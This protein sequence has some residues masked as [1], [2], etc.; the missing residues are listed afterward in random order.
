[1]R[2]FFKISGWLAVFL[3]T[4]IF[5]I[6][7]ALQSPGVQTFLA[8]K[9]LHFIEGTVNADISFEKVHVRP[10]NALVLKDV[11]IVDRDPFIPQGE[12]M[13]AQQD[14]FF[15][16]GY[17]TATFSLK[18]LF[19]GE[20]LH[21][22][23]VT[24]KDGL[25]VLAT[26]PTGSNLKRIIQTKKKEKKEKKG[27]AIF[28]ANRVEVD[29]MEFRLVNF[30][31]PKP[32]REGAI[33]W[34]DLDVF[35]INL[36]GRK[37]RFADGVM[38]GIADHLSFTEK[39]GYVVRDMSGKASVGN[40]RTK[41][42][43][44]HIL[45]G[46]SNLK[47]SSFSMSYPDMTA[48]KDFV[49]RVY[50]EADIEPSV[51][52]IE[53]VAYFA[54]GLHKN[55]MRV[56]MRTKFEGYVS[57]FTVKGLKFTE[58][59][60][61]MTA[62][63]DGGIIGLPDSQGM[64][65]DFDVKNMEFT[66]S[67]LSTFIKGW[68]PKANLNLGNI[69]PGETFTMSAKAKGPLNRLSAQADI[70]SPSGG[71]IADVDLRNLIDKKRDI[72]I[73][74]QI[75]TRDLEAGRLLSIDKIGNASVT[76]NLSATLSKG[77]P[78]V[79]ID[80]VRVNSLEALGY[81]FNGISGSGSYG[82]D[83]LTARIESSDPNLDVDL[84]AVMKKTKDGP[85]DYSVNGVI[86]NVDLHELGFDSKEVSKVSMTLGSDFSLDGDGGINGKADIGNLVLEDASG[87]HTIGDIH[88]EGDD[89]DGRNS[90]ALKSSFLDADYSGSEF[91]GQF[92]KDLLGITVQR[93]L[94]A[95][96]DQNKD[97]GKKKKKAEDTVPYSPYDAEGKYIGGNYDVK[98][99]LHDTRN[100]LSFLAPG[101]YIADSSTVRI[102]IGEDGDLT[103]KVVS[104][105]IAMG[106]K[107]LKDVN[108]SLN[109]EDDAIRGDLSTSELNISPLDVLDG[110]VSL[111]ASHNDFGA[112]LAFDNGTVPEN[113][114]ELYLTGNFSRSE[115]DA[116]RMAA[117]F[118]PS[119]IYFNGEP[120]NIVSDEIRMVGSD[121]SV[122]NLILTNS[123]Q[124]INIDGGIS[125]T[126]ADTLR[127]DLKRF[128]ISIA[129]AFIPS[130]PGI[131]GLATGNAVL[132][133][134]M[135]GDLGILV[136]LTTE[137]TSIA[138]ENIGSLKLNSSWDDEIKAMKIA[139][140]NE[141]NG[142]N[143][144]DLIG[145]YYTSDKSIA[146]TLDL[147]KFQI[148]YFEPFIESLFSTMDGTVSGKVD[149]QGPTNN[150]DIR[151]SDLNIDQAD[152]RLAFTNVLYKAKGAL[153]IDAGGVYFTDVSLAD[154]GRGTGK[155]TGKIGWDHLKDMLLGLRVDF[156]GMQ[157][158]DAPE[159][160]NPS[161][162]G[163]AYANGSAVITGPFN[164]INLDITATT[165]DNGE[166]HLPLGGKGSAKISD[167]LIFK[168]E[169][170]PVYLDPY[171]E[172]MLTESSK[173]KKSNDLQVK[174]RVNVHSGVEALVEV[175][176]DSGNVLTG[177]GTGRIELDV[178]PAKAVFDL[179]GAY[180]LQSGNYHLDV[181]GIAKRDFQIQD[182][183]SIHF[184]GDVME[185]D[186]DINGIYRT[187]A[188]IG[189]LI[190]DTTS[191]ARRTIDCGI[192]ITGK[193]KNPIVEFSLEVPDIDPSTQAKVSS[194][195]STQDRIQKQFLAL[196][197]TGAFLPDELGG[198][199]NN[200]DMIGNTFSEMM[201]SQLSAILQEFNIPVD[202]GLEYGGS[203]QFDVALS[204]ELFDNRV[205]VNGTF[206]NKYGN[207]TGSND[208][209][210]DLD[211][212]VKLDRSGALRLN[213]F[214]HSADQYTRYLD[215]SQR[216]GVGITY[217]REFN[218]FKRF[219]SDMFTSKKKKALREESM[220][221]RDPSDERMTMEI[222]EETSS[223]EEREL[224][225]EEKR[226]WKELRKN[227]R[228]GQ[229]V[230]EEPQ[231]N[232]QE[233]GQQ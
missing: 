51:L 44:L 105:R 39:S 45:D 204:T 76:A 65:M 160:H 154:T 56:D 157:V 192:S 202:V 54:P 103:G 179:G 199:N 213:L 35:D 168:Q 8:K 43:N 69:A 10:F 143:N 114:G 140:S 144:I 19:R 49:N 96:S 136:D 58:K 162:Y 28:D 27:G 188:A 197:V 215:N 145:N 16:A 170:I 116:L 206:G 34:A 59:N 222:R 95:L 1:M 208:V 90:L 187:K 159:G 89:T 115:E 53:T 42:D 13:P 60:S 113:K 97:S 107:F 217:Q 120:W 146:A 218:N 82:K 81:N 171:E 79:V 153:G 50:L 66:T 72:Q 123:E 134:P 5:A 100:L 15:R 148:G 119:G 201:A 57:D 221:G 226:R 191:T 210:G 36:S 68:A 78:Q 135:K 92:V 80:T 2:K 33:N 193:L 214:S 31:K 55:T 48:W 167:L 9:A 169:E 52:D 181:M 127:L 194:A 122:G 11:A 46:W 224:T 25:F 6:V 7:I 205:I 102:G 198:V 14:T 230:E 99:N 165:V 70:S 166:F 227:R 87:A 220:A 139:V 23:T 130:S 196:L 182:G 32:P 231:E 229:P 180:N 178:R 18:G 88:L 142:E 172:M 22:G 17:L 176:K 64:M 219:L 106:A 41:I 47:M 67:G 207:T 155:V 128:D 38:E 63:V 98:V 104:K 126:K 149:I 111:Y 85:T 62:S 12:G 173:S 141:L 158:L 86:Y 110:K 137:S 26:D 61:G 29:N 84:N 203:D 151:S 74:G 183:S 152:L 233:D 3:L 132:I 228:K 174:L 161:F 4:V 175:D 112:M 75:T 211:I 147:N 83:G 131:A 185:A 138:G 156:N 73:S 225:K 71:V 216:N 108:L 232:I 195:L 150:L 109:N 117:Q 163:K 184:G 209:V 200:F 24:V 129:D 223:A 164:A 40:G 133:S 20:G 121:I 124:Y 21:L 93:H 37:L 91:V 30:K 190:S 118:I 212:E 186:L 177:R 77:G 125:P 94:S 189:T 101:V